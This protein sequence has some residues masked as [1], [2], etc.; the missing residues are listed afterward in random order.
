M[1]TLIQVLEQILTVKIALSTRLV[2]MIPATQPFWVSILRLPLRGTLRSVLSGANYRRPIIKCINFR[3]LGYGLRTMIWTFPDR[4]RYLSMLAVASFQNLVV[5]YGW[6]V[7]VCRQ[8]LPTVYRFLLFCPS[9]CMCIR[10]SFFLPWF[11]YFTKLSTMCYTS[12]I[13][14]MRPTT[15]WVWFRLKVLVMIVYTY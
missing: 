3:V 15:T 13:W 9:A 2:H 14:R 7:L 12:I 10:F 6:L 11:S 4:S 1:I 8:I 5:R